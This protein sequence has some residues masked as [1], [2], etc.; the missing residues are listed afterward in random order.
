MRL[1]RKLLKKINRKIRQKLH[2]KKKNLH[3]NDVAHQQFN[4][5]N[6]VNQA[7][8]TNDVTTAKIMELQPLML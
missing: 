1:I 2:K 3:L 4:A 8:T 7:N 6:N 5:N